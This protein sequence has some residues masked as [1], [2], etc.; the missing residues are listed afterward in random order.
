MNLDFYGGKYGHNDCNI[1]FGFKATKVFLK[2]TLTDE[3]EAFFVRDNEPL[4]LNIKTVSIHAG[5]LSE[6]S[7]LVTVIKKITLWPCRLLKLV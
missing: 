2:S 5:F 4:L 7:F 1:D 3:I 6:G